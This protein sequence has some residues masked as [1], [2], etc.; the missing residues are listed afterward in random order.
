MALKCE[1]GGKVIVEETLLNRLEQCQKC[2][3][4]ILRLNEFAASALI[5]LSQKEQ[6]IAELERLYR[7]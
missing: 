1:C 4:E 5:K 7:L 2:G 6:E 3:K